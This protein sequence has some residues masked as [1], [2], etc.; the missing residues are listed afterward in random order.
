M[1]ALAP[2]NTTQSLPST[3]L[4]ARPVNLRQARLMNGHLGSMRSDVS[5]RL[6]SDCFKSASVFP[7]RKLMRSEQSSRLGRRSIDGCSRVCTPDAEV[8]CS[9]I[10]EA[11][12]DP[13]TRLVEMEYRSENTDVGRSSLRA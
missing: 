2:K 10:A 3:G 9:E 5:D 4:R 6:T 13:K 8:R 12:A 1:S 11:P 7:N